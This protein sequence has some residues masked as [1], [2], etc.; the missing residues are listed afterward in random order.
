M[1]LTLF[2][3]IIVNFT[4]HAFLQQVIEALQIFFV[5]AAETGDSIH[6]Y[7]CHYFTITGN[8]YIIIRYRYHLQSH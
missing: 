6:N 4:H 3:Q 5:F 8:V 2:S 7:Q 1:M